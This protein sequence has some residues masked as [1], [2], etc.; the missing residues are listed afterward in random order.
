M[1]KAIRAALAKGDASDPAYR[2]KV[3]RSAHAALERALSAPN[4]TDQAIDQ[5]RR[6]FLQT[7][8]LVEEDY[9]GPRH[10]AAPQ[11]TPQAAP[12]PAPVQPTPNIDL[13][14]R[15]GA[16]RPAAAPQPRS[17]ARIEP[18]LDIRE[19]PL[20]EYR[21]DSDLNEDIPGESREIRRRGRPFLWLFLIAT[22]LAMIGVAL[23]WVY[24]SGLS[25]SPSQRNGAVPNPANTQEESFDPAQPNGATGGQVGPR[26]DMDIDDPNATTIFTA[27]DPQG[28]TVPADAQSEAV[29]EG[30]AQL[31][32][33]RSGSSGSAVAFDV[34]RET[35]AGLSGRRALFRIS[36]RAEEGDPTQI[37]VSCSFGEMGDCGRQRYE[38][39]YERGDFIFD[40]DM[41]NVQPGADGTISIVSDVDKAGK[42][43]DVYAIEVSANDQ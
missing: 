29:R 4:L 9:T 27:N 32:R 15:R 35:L 14:D 40:V 39:G 37:S 21:I 22:L 19:E 5:R 13:D 42:A 31:L 25:L 3:Y 43:L 26:S 30:S 17:D 12:T 8:E 6:A 11:T 38:V 7:V 20:D 24:G 41:P 28:V 18:R 33:I 36:A 2:D 23:W 16:P 1:E 10:A 34:S